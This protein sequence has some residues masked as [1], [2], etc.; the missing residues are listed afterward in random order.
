MSRI[1]YFGSTNYDEADQFTETSVNGTV[2]GFS[3]IVATSSTMAI[4]FYNQAG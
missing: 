3:A 1:W 2:G 4:I